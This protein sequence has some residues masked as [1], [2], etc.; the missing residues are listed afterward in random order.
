MIAARQDATGAREAD[1]H[2]S[3]ALQVGAELATPVLRGWLEVGVVVGQYGRELSERAEILGSG[4]PKD[5]KKGG[6]ST[7]SAR[8]SG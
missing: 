5:D 7:G 2:S 1:K 3:W 8:R 6:A 4:T